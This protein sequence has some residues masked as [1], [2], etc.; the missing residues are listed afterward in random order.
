LQTWSIFEQVR[1]FLGDRPIWKRQQGLILSGQGRT[2]DALPYFEAA[3]AEEPEAYLGRVFLSFALLSTMQY[4]AVLERGSDL[5]KPFVLWH[6]GRKEEA[7]MTANSVAQK[8]DDP[9]V[10]M[11]FFDLENDFESVIGV[12]N[13]RWQNLDEYQEDNPG[14]SYGYD[15][16]VVVARAY[17]MTGDEEKF[18]D[19][20]RR[21]EVALKNQREQGSTHL[22]LLGSEAKLAMLLGDEEGAL[23]KI[24]LL[25]SHGIA[26]PLFKQVN[27]IF[28]PLHADERFQAAVAQLRQYAHRERENNCG[29]MRT[30]SGKNSDCPRSEKEWTFE[31]FL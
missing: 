4:E 16:M 14:I 23:N 19:A 26:L 21:L 17:K 9:A 11:A 15:E 13:S 18:T 30:V 12:Y 27:P 5:H 31:Q 28:E 3:T 20:A 22:S 2:A 24:E 1:P 10:V 25:V 29:N 6:L 7:R 8:Y